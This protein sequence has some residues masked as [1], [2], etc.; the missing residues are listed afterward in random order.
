MLDVKGIKKNFPILRRQINGHPLAY[1]DNASTTQKPHAVIEALTNFYETKNANVHRGVYTLSQ[2]ASIAY[3]GARETVRDFINAA[4]AEE[5]IFTRNATEAIN[6][7]AYSFAR[8]RLKKG[9]IIM[10]S[11]LEH[12]SNLVPWQQVCEKTGARLDIIP[13]ITDPDSEKRY[14]LD[15][16]W[17]EKHLSKKVKLVALAHASNVTGTI[18]PVKKYIDL[19]H[20]VGAKVLIDGAQSAAHMPTDV[21]TM[22]CDF[23]AFS[24]HK[25][26]GPTGAGVL[27]A[28]RDILETM[29][30]F[31]FGG[32][33]IRE[34][35]ARA[36]TWNDLPWKFEAGTPNIEG[37]IG[38]AEAIR[39]IQKIGFDHM[40]AHE[41]RLL[42]HAK[43]H[44]SSIA[45]L[46]IF[47][48][49]N[50]ADATGI[51][52]FIMQGVHPHD[53]AEIFDQYSIAIRGG[54]HCAQPLMETLK[55]P[56]TARMSFA[57][58]N[59]EEEIDRSIEAIHRVQKIFTRPRA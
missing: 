13:L 34:V 47:S 50:T 23:L 10:V 4:H 49:H 8:E 6:L 21:Q 1:L 40:Q 33:M 5:I 58:Y 38:L 32:D 35:H 15:I 52:S 44:L 20:R 19:A 59:T 28:P 41:Q 7:V 37:A 48:P 11:E 36:S 22:G 16:A 12:H 24:S 54:H 14:M 57:V 31:L 3:E 45:H 2:E 26:Y 46:R 17:Y 43:R 53:I 51:L 29:P 27:Y 42:A 39:F 56:A 30:P 25:M 18:N 9:D 55:I